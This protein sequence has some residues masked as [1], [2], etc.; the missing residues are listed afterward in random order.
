VFQN[1]DTGRGVSIRIIAFAAFS[2]LCYFGAAVII[3]ILLAVLLAYVLE[4]LVTLLRR[5]LVP[6]PLAILIMMLVTGVIV[7]ALVFLFIDRAQ[8]FSD[9][10][11]R[12]GKKIQKI[13]FDIRTRI[14]NLE[15]KSQDIGTQILPEAK[16]EP[17][18]IKIQQ[19]SS[20]RDFVFRD[21][22]PFYERLLL[23]SFFPFLVYFLLSEKEQVRTFV[24]GFIRSRTSLS[25]TFVMDT[26]EKIVNDFND[27]IRGF[28]FGYLLSTAILFFTTWLMFIAFGVQQA[29]IWCFLYTLLNM[30]PFVGAILGMIPPVL[31]AILQFSSLRLGIVFLTLCLLLHLLYANWLI[32]RTTGPRTQL[33]PL[34]A[35]IA[36]M[37]WGFL[38]GAIGIFLAIPITAVLRSVWMQYR[39]FVLANRMEME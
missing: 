23:I 4:P 8:E 12:Y 3:T 24:A 36:M 17:Q 15:K 19:Y 30:L 38:W 2:A 33:T 5:I 14:R 10:L 25:Q 37:Y 6:R 18:P 26:S 7:A 31:I 28:V 11:P 34:T 29:F 35:L 13:S 9:N 27:K 22:G 39:S 16:K 21:L 32:P 1:M 20:W